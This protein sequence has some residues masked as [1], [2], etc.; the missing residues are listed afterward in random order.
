VDGHVFMVLYKG[1]KIRREMLSLV[2]EDEK[3]DVEQLKEWV[4]KEKFDAKNFHDYIVWIPR[5]V[6]GKFQIYQKAG[7]KKVP[8]F[9]SEA[10]NGADATFQSL[11]PLYTPTDSFPILVRFRKQSRVIPPLWVQ[12]E[13]G[14]PVQLQW[15]APTGSKRP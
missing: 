6:K 9:Y 8:P 10:V 12:L 3:M 1:G 13:K 15:S 5:S 2:Q 7:N 14:P 11:F 4:T